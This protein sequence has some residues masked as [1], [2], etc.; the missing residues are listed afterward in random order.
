MAYKPKYAQSKK[1]KQPEL[2]PA[3]A[4]K[5]AKKQR[6]KAGKIIAL[7]LGIVLIPASIA[8]TGK[9]M[10]GMLQNLGR[11]KTATIHKTQNMTILADFDAAVSASLQTARDGIAGADKPEIQEEEVP[12]V[13]KVY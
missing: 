13:R 9:L 8:V 6:G 10:G 7:I 3:P 2:T 1:K 5:P 4:P 12:P 11:P